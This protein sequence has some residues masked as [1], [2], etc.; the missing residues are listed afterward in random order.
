MIEG[1]T[2][3]D[4]DIKNGVKMKCR[5]KKYFQEKAKKLK[6]KYTA[7]FINRKNTKMNEFEVNDRVLYMIQ[8]KG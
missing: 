5:G 4:F 1:E 2:L 6:E 7:E 3:N 8:R